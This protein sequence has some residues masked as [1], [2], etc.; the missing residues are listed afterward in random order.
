MKRLPACLLTLTLLSPFALFA[1]EKAQ[2]LRNQDVLAMFEAKLSPAVIV[3]KIESS[4]CAFDTQPAALQ[5][6]KSKGVAEEIILAMIRSET[7]PTVSN[8]HAER[9]LKI[10]IGAPVEI[11]SKYEINSAEVRAGDVLTFSV[12]EPIKIGG[13]TVIEAGARVTGKV[14]KAHKGRP[15]G[16]AGR[17]AW[18]VQSAMAVNGERVPLTL[19]NNAVGDSKGGTVATATI[20][21]AV[22]LLPAAPVALLWGFKRGKPAIIPAGKV[23][24]AFVQTETTISLK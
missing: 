8:S 14:T 4:P 15:F 1:Q 11:I 12:S 16:K 9:T 20:A 2:P 5:E 10:P 18:E 3:T 17:L 19:T 21:T 6:L 13:V 22:L 23:F 24:N 7:A